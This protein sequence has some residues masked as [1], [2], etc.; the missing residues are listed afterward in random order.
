MGRKLDCYWLRNLNDDILFS[1]L[2]GLNIDKNSMDSP[3]HE[4]LL[5]RLFIRC[6]RAKGHKGHCFHHT[7]FNKT[8]KKCTLEFGSNLKDEIIKQ[9]G[10]LYNENKRQKLAYARHITRKEGTTYLA[11]YNPA[12]R[13][14]IEEIIEDAALKIEMYANH[15]LGAHQWRITKVPGISETPI[16]NHILLEQDYARHGAIFFLFLI[17]LI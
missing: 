4:E 13:M 7:S 12:C 8:C 10:P 14:R 1:L 6:Q 2:S 9:M 3:V 16:G 5:E 11:E 15:Y 17:S